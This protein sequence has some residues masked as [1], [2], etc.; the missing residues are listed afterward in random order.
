MRLS[1]KT[2]VGKSRKCR[3]TP[4][5]SFLA[6]TVH[7]V[8]SLYWTLIVFGKF[9]FSCFK[10]SSQLAIA[11]YTDPARTMI[12]YSVLTS[13]A[14]RWSLT[15][16]LAIPDLWR[17]SLPVNFH[18]RRESERLPRSSNYCGDSEAE[19]LLRQPLIPWHFL[20][21]PRAKVIA[22]THRL[23]TW[24]CGLVLCLWCGVSWVL[25]DACALYSAFRSGH[26]SR[27]RFCFFARE[28]H[29]PVAAPSLN[30]EAW[31]LSGSFNGKWLTIFSL[32]ECQWWF[33]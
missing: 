29:W 9:H 19:F 3:I 27:C 23:S 2:V 24:M 33:F 32:G 17:F 13:L 7:A 31:F 8:D 15:S 18:S 5:Q 26:L 16:A 1:R 21:S 11:S 4:W 20:L 30:T 6:V 12:Q 14:S 22:V 25:C 28:P 10:F